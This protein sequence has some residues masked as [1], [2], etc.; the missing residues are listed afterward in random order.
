MYY[1]KKERVED[2]LKEFLNAYK[3][4]PRDPDTLYNIGLIYRYY[5]Y[6]YD[7]ARVF[8][9]K[10]LELNPPSREVEKVKEILAEIEE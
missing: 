5:L 10:Y 3:L 4:Q 2:A 1:L 6:D 8:L 9:N 7:K